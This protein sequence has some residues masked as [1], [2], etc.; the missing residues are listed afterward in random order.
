MNR[1]LTTICRITAAT[2]IYFAASCSGGGE[3][4]VPRPSANPRIEAPD[5][6][7]RK[8]NGV[9]ATWIVNEAAE[10][11]V[12]SGHTDGST[13]LNVMYPRGEAT[14]FCTFTPV[15]PAT[16]GA[17]IENRSERMALNAGNNQSEITSF[18]SS[19]G[20]E[21]NLM[22]TSHGTVTPL[23]FIATSP[24]MVVTG[25]VYIPTLTEATNDSLAPVVEYLK[26]DVMS[27]LINLCP[28]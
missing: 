8:V 1:A 23:Q 25:A 26:R 21:I 24:G 18:K 16:C 19:G 17:V 6:V 2:T 14:M 3:V 4:A 27:A 22:E 7:Y 9:P 10:D 11:S 15:T 20:F 12:S 13:W 28:Q 5:S